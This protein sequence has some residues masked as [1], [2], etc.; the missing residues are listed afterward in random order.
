M[1]LHLHGGLSARQ[2]IEAGSGPALRGG[3]RA[4]QRAD[5]APTTWP[6]LTPVFLA[7]RLV[8]CQAHLCLDIFVSSCVE[9]VHYHRCQ[10]LDKIS[11]A[12]LQPFGVVSAEF[13]LLTNSM[14]QLLR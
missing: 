9:P 5:E 4:E 6:D 10:P 13:L 3:V 14:S 11:D 1:Q 2:T 7:E 8:A 12:A